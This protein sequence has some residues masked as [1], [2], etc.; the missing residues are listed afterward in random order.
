MMAWKCRTRSRF[1]GV[2]A[3][4]TVYASHL[5]LMVTG[6]TC[7][8]LGAL[9]DLVNVTC[10]NSCSSHGTCDS[11]TALCSC[12]DGWGSA[13]DVAQYKAPDCSL[14][15]CPSDVS[16]NVNLQSR[17]L[18]ERPVAECSDRGICNRATGM[19]NCASGFLGSACSRKTCE[20][21][22]SGRGECVSMKTAAIVD[23]E[24]PL[25]EQ[26]QYGQNDTAWDS[27]MIYGC[28]CDSDSWTVGL[29]A[30]EYQVSE[31][32]GPQC[33]LKRCPSGDDPQTEEDE[34]DCEGVNGGNA[35]NLCY[36]PCSNRGNCDDRTGRC[37]CY[38]GYTGENCEFKGYS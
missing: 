14:R 38:D 10:P 29:G 3:L 35:G 23:E 33:S 21:S 4:V 20:R 28:I 18:S 9:N 22:C 27:E 11:E 31:Y 37:S 32:F 1:G 25:L 34:T 16:W 36:V 6:Q 12:D 5:A 17:E 15:T 26:F 30:G 8:N 7:G 24:Y 19:C 2:S 13:T